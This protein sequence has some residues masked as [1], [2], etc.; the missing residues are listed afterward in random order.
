MSTYI[1]ICPSFVF[2]YLALCYVIIIVFKPTH[3]FLL[4]EGFLLN[5]SIITKIKV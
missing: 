3:L 2:R 1:N 5:Y 4:M